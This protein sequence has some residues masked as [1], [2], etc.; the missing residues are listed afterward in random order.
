MNDLNSIVIEGRMNEEP[1]V[2]KGSQDSTVVMATFYSSRY[3]KKDGS[4]KYKAIPFIAFLFGKMADTFIG[5]IKTGDKVRLVGRLG[6]R[7]AGVVVI[8]E[9]YSYQPADTLEDGSE[10]IDCKM[11]SEVEDE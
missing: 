9:H 4:L 5:G 8:V 6:H 7:E 3:Y 10:W 11:I 2:T 1:K